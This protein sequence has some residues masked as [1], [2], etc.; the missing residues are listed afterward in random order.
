MHI[1]K[2]GICIFHKPQKKGLFYNPRGIISRE[3]GIAI[4]RTESKEKGNISLAEC[5]AG[6]GFRTIRYYKEAGVRNIAAN[7]GNIE[8]IEFLKENLKLNEIPENEIKITNMDAKKFLLESAINGNRFDVIDLD[9]FG[10]PS[11]YIFSAVLALKIDGLVYFTST[12]GFT[13]C[14]LKKEASIRNYGVHT[15]NS[16]FC[17]ELGARVV[18]SQF[19]KCAGNLSMHFEPVIT[20]YDGYAWRIALR[21]KKG[22][23]NANFDKFGYVVYNSKTKEYK[24]YN[25]NYI[26]T[27][28]LICGP[29]YLGNIHDKEYVKKLLEVSKDLT[30]V[31]KVL[32][33]IINE[34]DI[35]LYY[36]YQ[37]IC[38][39]ISISPPPRK[40]IINKLRKLGYIASESHFSPYSIK[41]NAS[42]EEFIKVLKSIK[43]SNNMI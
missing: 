17:H 16:K 10:S 31:R 28:G 11:E 25:E 36:N 33:K 40:K 23:E 26:D 32:E 29:V 22:V 41:T 4:L 14:G 9:S 21:L 3:L 19:M 13:L 6:V 39:I 38:D 7:E 15:I 5:M 34:E 42:Y 24:L 37:E 2:E 20:L 12:D 18:I 30:N 8:A 27:S 43:P 35:P 1:I